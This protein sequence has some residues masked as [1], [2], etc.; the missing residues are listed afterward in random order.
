PEALMH[1]A[2]RANVRAAV[3]Q[4]KHG[5][6][7]LENLIESRGLLVVGA[8]YEISDGRVHFFYGLPGSA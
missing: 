6:G 1:E 8:E 3:N 4:L 7:I 5:S 2:M